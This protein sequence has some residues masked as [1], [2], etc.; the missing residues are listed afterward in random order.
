MACCHCPHPTCEYSLASNAVAT[1]PECPTGYLAVN[2]VGGGS[3]N[4]AWLSKLKYQ[5]MSKI[6]FIMFDKTLQTVSAL[7][8]FNV[9][10][11]V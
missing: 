1:C 2:S 7:Y 11:H 5:H 10:S 9:E 3:I 8:S 6:L 4:R